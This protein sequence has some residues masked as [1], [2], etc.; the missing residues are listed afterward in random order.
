MIV[1]DAKLVTGE[2]AYQVAWL[3]AMENR[4]W[5]L[6]EGRRVE[7]LMVAVRTTSSG[8]DSEEPRGI[9]TRAGPVL[10]DNKVERRG[11]HGQGR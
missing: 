6:R 9:I 10:G 4:R 8:M 5:L 2:W 7:S 3:F 11:F 1:T